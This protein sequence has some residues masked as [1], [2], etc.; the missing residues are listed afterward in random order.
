MPN[1]LTCK[2]HKKWN[3]RG[4]KPNEGSPNTGFLPCT[5][6]RGIRLRSILRHG[7]CPTFYGIFIQ[8]AKRN[9]FC[10]GGGQSIQFPYDPKK[11]GAKDVQ[12][13]P[14]K[15]L[16]GNPAHLYPCRLRPGGGPM[17]VYALVFFFYSGESSMIQVKYVARRCQSLPKC[18]N[19][20]YR[21]KVDC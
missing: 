13:L 1:T 18:Q 3:D 2:R 11:H 19:V 12:R 15:G 14:S 16:M 20:F 9:N 6:R 8:A 7:C 17:T 21:K 5:Y 4:N 10:K